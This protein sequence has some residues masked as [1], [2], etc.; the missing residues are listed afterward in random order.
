[1]FFRCF[2][3]L[4]RR[5]W[6]GGFCTTWWDTGSGGLWDFAVVSGNCNEL[7]EK[8]CEKLVTVI[9]KSYI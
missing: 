3:S 9:K 6:F 8:K 2:A 7:R 4:R 1:M 5:R